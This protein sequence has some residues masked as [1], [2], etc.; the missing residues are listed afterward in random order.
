MPAAMALQR[1]GRDQ[2]M[3]PTATH[4][5]STSARPHAKT[6]RS[7]PASSGGAASAGGT[8]TDSSPKRCGQHA[9]AAQ[10]EQS[11]ARAARA[12]KTA[13]PP[14]AASTRSKQTL[15]ANARFSPPSSVTCTTS[16][17]R[18]GFSDQHMG[19]RFSA[20]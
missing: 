1:I 6:Q 4:G 2:R 3:P 20:P 11:G 10:M 14:A 12:V 7:R 18:A 15:P 13:V 5:R 8:K 16:Q 19:P 17:G 9:A